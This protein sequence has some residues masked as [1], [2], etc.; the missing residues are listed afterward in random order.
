MGTRRAGLSGP[1]W[2]APVLGPRVSELHAH[3]GVGEERVVA[4]GWHPVALSGCEDVPP[5]RNDFA[6]DVT[7]A[8]RTLFHAQR[9]ARSAARGEGPWSA[10]CAG[11][12]SARG[13]CP[14]R[15][16]TR[17]A[18]SISRPPS[19]PTPRRGPKNA[20]RESSG[21]PARG[22]HPPVAADRRP[23]PVPGPKRRSSEATPV[24]SRRRQASRGQESSRGR[25]W[26]GDGM[27]DAE[28][29]DDDWLGSPWPCPRR[30]PTPKTRG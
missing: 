25:A 4:E 28:R 21:C 30:W 13:H 1:G 20:A 7:V 23:S 19:T 6:R 18:A 8:G 9:S 16:R 11:W 27:T 15:R 5:P 22:A 10:P 24:T 3:F 17:T 2:R 12:T 29:H 14:T 26:E